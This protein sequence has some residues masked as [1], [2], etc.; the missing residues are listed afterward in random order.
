MDDEAVETVRR[1]RTLPGVEVEGIFTHFARADE[2]DKTYA[3][4]Q[5][6]PFQDFI[7]RVEKTLTAS[8]S[9]T[10]P[11]ARLRSCIRPHIWIWSARALSSMAIFQTVQWTPVFA[12]WSPYWN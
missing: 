8:R 1:I 10:V 3:Y 9:I 4:E 12:T 2:E 5:L 7:R 6:R 11:T